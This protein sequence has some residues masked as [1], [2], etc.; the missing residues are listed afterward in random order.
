MRG[1]ES[2]YDANGNLLL[3]R[4]PAVIELGFL[5]YGSGHLHQ[6]IVG[7]APFCDIERD[8][9]HVPRMLTHKALVSRL[10]YDAAQQL[11][12]ID[13]GLARGGDE[14]AD[15][16]P[17]PILSSSFAYD[18]DGDLVAIDRIAPWGREGMRFRYDADRRVV[19][20]GGTQ[21]PPRPLYWDE[22]SNP[23]DGPGQRAQDNMVRSLGAMSAGY[24]GFGRLRERQ[25]AE[26][27][28]GLEWNAFHE[29]VGV[30]GQCHG[31]SVFEQYAYDAF[32]RR[33]TK[34][35]NGSE[36]AFTWEGERL[37]ME[38]NDEERRIFVYHDDSQEPIGFILSPA[39]PPEPGDAD[40][41]RRFV[42]LHDG[43]SGAP[44]ALT[45]EEGAVLWH[46]SYDAFGAATATDDSPAAGRLP[47]Q[48]LRLQGQYFDAATGLC[49]NRFRY[50]DPLDGRFISPD[51]IGLLGGE[52]V[53]AYAPNPFAWIDPLGLKL[54]NKIDGELRQAA[55]VKKIQKDAPAGAKL[56]EECPL[57][58]C[59]SGKIMKDTK[60]TGPKNDR[61]Y[62]TRRLDVV[63]INK[64]AVV[65]AVE[66]TS[67]TASKDDQLAKEDRIRA[68]GGTCIKDRETKELIPV[69]MASELMRLP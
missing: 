11:T 2:E 21:L 34:V 31:E 48:P 22:A 55:A 61:R 42:Y 23:I 37:L 35:T 1:F 67:K 28:L 59:K 19:A 47:V 17:T 64:G 33:I 53:Y 25:S 20:Q 51:P 58:S 56:Q 14:A 50:F 57:R 13:T 8:A 32:G 16:A 41:E 46:A 3:T 54:Q 43:P 24:D 7:G 44:F 66:V 30:R 26:G 63:V 62:R 45:D 65:R 6:I 5:H 4:I 15:P 9:S 40:G 36:I 39:R 27:Q 69:P 38:E 49:Y 52:N 29:L 68:R 10:R 18:P 12:G 60:K